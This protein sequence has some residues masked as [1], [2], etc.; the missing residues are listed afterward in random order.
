MVTIS[1]VWLVSVTMIK[2]VGSYLR[3]ISFQNDLVFYSPST[4]TFA[5]GHQQN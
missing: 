2:K 4:V 1:N 5:S 3:I